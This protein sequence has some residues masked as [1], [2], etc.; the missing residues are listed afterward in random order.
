[1]SD[2]ARFKRK[3]NIIGNQKIRFRFS[4]ALKIK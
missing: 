2:C 3:E 1:L 4:P